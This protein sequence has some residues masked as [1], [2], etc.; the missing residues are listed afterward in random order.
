MSKLF[1]V[2]GR[3][4]GSSG[5]AAACS[6]LEDREFLL[7]L[8]PAHINAVDLER[9]PREGSLS[10]DPRDLPAPGIRAIAV[11]AKTDLLAKV[12][13]ASPGL[14]KKSVA[15]S[16]ETG[17]NSTPNTTKEFE[18]KPVKVVNGRDVIDMSG[19]SVDIYT[20][21][22]ISGEDPSSS[23]STSIDSTLFQKVLTRILGASGLLIG[24]LFADWLFSMLWS[25]FFE[26]SNQLKAWEPLKIWLFLAI[27]MGVGGFGFLPPIQ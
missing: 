2:R 17:A 3:V 6:S 27:S 22:G 14:F 12:S 7:I 24:L 8:A 4:K 9:I 10:T 1:I 15:G 23:S 19:T 13:L 20:L 18:C 21:L 25:I 16:K 26:Q 11:L 5:D